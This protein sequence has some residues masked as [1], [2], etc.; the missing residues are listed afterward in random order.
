MTNPSN[1]PAR[2]PGDGE[3]IR[4][5][6]DKAMPSAEDVRVAD[7][8]KKEPA[9]DEER[10]IMLSGESGESREYRAP[11][12]ESRR[13][14]RRR[15]KRRWR[16]I[17][18]SVLCCFLGLLL[19]LT[20]GFFLSSEL[21]R[22][23]LL[24]DT[25]SVQPPKALTEEIEDD[26]RILTYRGQ[27]YQYN[28]NIVSVLCMGMDK[29]RLSDGSGYGKNGQADAIFLAALDTKT[30]VVKVL[31]ISRETMVE[32]NETTMQGQ[33]GGIV[34]AQLCLAYAYGNDPVSGSENMALSV[35]RLLY[36]I[37]PD[38]TVV[39]DQNGLGK[40]STLLGGIT[41]TCN[42]DIREGSRTFKKDKEYRLKGDD[43]RSYIQMRG[44]DLEGNQRR[45]ER[46]KEVLRALVS[47]AAKKVSDNPASLLTLYNKMNPY[48]KSTLTFNEITYLAS[49]CLTTDLGKSFEYLSIKG[50]LREG[51]E[52][53]YAEFYPDEASV[54]EAVLALYYTPVK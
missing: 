1:D 5:T 30:G 45:M 13:Q 40:L 10:N 4:L 35:Q 41:V 2:I 14:A 37:A 22:R 29:D 12:S 20:G 52:T 53:L 54:Y 21:G 27:R 47:A 16:K 49:R 19:V 36:G 7:L 48:F 34:T 24:G 8:A 42:E 32:I 18:L 17:S 3:E 50:E 44:G 33:D 26:G 6:G 43:M 51:K 11:V 25:P 15:Q 46:E 31:P 28:E 38:A 23:S 39:M 9:A